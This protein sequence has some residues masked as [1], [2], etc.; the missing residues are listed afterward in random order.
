MV[1]AIV[2]PAKKKEVAESRVL[3][4]VNRRCLNVCYVV[5]E[6]KLIINYLEQPHKCYK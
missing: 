6:D 5:V 3:I 2:Q 4:D 1:Y